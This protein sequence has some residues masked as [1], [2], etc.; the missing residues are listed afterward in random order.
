MY[1]KKNRIITVA[2]YPKSCITKLATE[3]AALKGVSLIDGSKE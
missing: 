3:R 2:G 1:R